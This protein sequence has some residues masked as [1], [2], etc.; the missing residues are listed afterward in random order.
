MSDQGQFGFLSEG[1][2]RIVRAIDI[3]VANG[4]EIP[5]DGSGT[6]GEREVF[7]GPIANRKGCYGS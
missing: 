3:P 1:R 6:K 5:C 2:A 7:N 4:E